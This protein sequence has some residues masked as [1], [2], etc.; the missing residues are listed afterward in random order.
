[1]KKCLFTGVATAIATPFNK[2]GVNIQEFK[3][4]IDFQVSSGINALVI[5][6]TTGESSTMSKQEKIDA[7]T[8]AVETVESSTQKIPIIVGT[9][10]NNTASAIEISILA[11][12]LGAD[13]LLVVA[14]YYNKKTAIYHYLGVAKSTY[15]KF[16]QGDKVKYK[17]YFYAL[18]PLLTCRYI[19]EK[20]EVPPIEFDR[21]LDTD[22]KDELRD[23]ETG[24]SG[25]G[26]MGKKVTKV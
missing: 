10:S 19:E 1:M 24:V 25:I 22:I 20:N 4:F 11:E 26:S 5:C 15:T 17:K 8:C 23:G 18:R 3:K 2:S 6:G 21:L 7:I 9:G 13:G 16:L 14:P 12:K